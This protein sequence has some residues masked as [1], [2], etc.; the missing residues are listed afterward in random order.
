ML[1]LI[2]LKIS[3]QISIFLHQSVP[4]LYTSI[5]YTVK[6]LVIMI[7]KPP[8]SKKLL[9]PGA[10]P[11]SSEDGCPSLKSSYFPK[12]KALLETKHGKFEISKEVHLKLHVF[13]PNFFHWTRTWHQLSNFIV[14]NNAKQ[15]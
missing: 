12:K 3:L 13:A 11:G 2:F 7:F 5:Q 9:C 15:F 14:L 4:K 8:S 10:A 1:E 6:N